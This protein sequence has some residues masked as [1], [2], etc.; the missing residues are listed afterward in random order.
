M[1][2][3]TMTTPVE[4]A[5]RSAYD[6][7]RNSWLQELTTG[8]SAVANVRFREVSCP[9]M[10]DFRKVSVGLGNPNQLRP[11]ADV[12]SKRRA[13]PHGVPVWPGAD[14]RRRD[15]LAPDQFF[16]QPSF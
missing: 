7:F 4:S 1:D 6:E 16:L 11:A 2:G 12:Q 10:P 8:R 9:V 3:L 13:R 14:L 5:R 15:S